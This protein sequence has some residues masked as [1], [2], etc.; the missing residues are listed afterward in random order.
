MKNIIIILISVISFQSFGQE[1]SENTI[2][3][4]S[5]FNSIIKNPETKLDRNNYPKGVVKEFYELQQKKDKWT[6]FKEYY[7]NGKI[8][9]KGVFLN[10]D[11]FNLWTVY[12]EKGDVISEIDYSDSKIIIGNQLGFD[13]LL[14]NCKSK[15]D[16]LINEHFGIDS[17]IKLNASRSYWYSENNSGTWFEKRDEQPTEFLLRYSLFVSEFNSFGI[18]ELHFDSDLN[19]IEKETKGLPKI[20]PY[21]FNISYDKA[22]EIAKS[23]NYGSINHK[24][25]FTES[26]YL[27][28][29]FDN[30]ND[31]YNWVISN[32]I[33]TKS[34][35][36]ENGKGGTINGIGT[37]LSIDCQTGN[38]EETKFE[39]SIIISH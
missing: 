25:A 21:Q 4:D 1:T 13:K 20:K 23:K 15:S 38:I 29:E 14:N 36:N 17:G 10:G 6:A 26:E 7:S 37:T 31:T 3:I 16:N 24:N 39:Q 18:I 19:L 2:N 12:N 28:L 35:E 30:D 27:D 8:K 34:L 32:V 22:M 5:L 9:E 33:K 11:Y